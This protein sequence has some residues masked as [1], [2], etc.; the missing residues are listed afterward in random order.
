MFPQGHLFL[1]VRV[2]RSRCDISWDVTLCCS[3]KILYITI[4]MT[5]AVLPHTLPPYP[6]KYLLAFFEKH[7]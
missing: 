3:E 1:F 7:F 5:L 6:T 2:W 4:Y